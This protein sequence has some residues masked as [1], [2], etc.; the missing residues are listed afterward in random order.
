MDSVYNLLKSIEEFEKIEVVFF[1]YSQKAYAHE[2]VN[3]RRISE[4]LKLKFIKVDL[5]WYRNLKSSLL[6]ENLKVSNYSEGDKNLAEW[7]PNRNA[8]FLNIAAAIA[9]SNNFDHIVIGIN[10][11][12]STRYKDNRKEF[13]NKLNELL[14]LSTLKKCKVI[15]YSEDLNKNEILKE[16]IPLMKKYDLDSSYIWSCYN[17][18]EKM[19]GK[20]ESCTRLKSAII[21][22]K[23]KE[24]KNLF[25]I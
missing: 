18:Y 9:E 11:E 2:Y 12:E 14:E 6:N 3:T 21:E 13:L 10:K 20:C 23:E 17:S 25:L 22:N 4:K 16:L 8:V 19:C 15:S 7:V 5:P 24:W 1:D